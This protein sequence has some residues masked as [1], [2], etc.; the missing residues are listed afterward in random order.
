MNFYSSTEYLDAVSDVYFPARRT[1]VQDVSIGN[2]ALRLLVVDERQVITDS[3]FLDYHQPLQDLDIRIPTRPHVYAE[4]VVKNVINSTE[5]DAEALNRYLPAPFIKWSN[6]SNYDDYLRYVKSRS[7]GALREENRLKRRLSENVGKLEFSFDDTREDVLETAL[8]WKSAQFV[9]TG[10]KDIFKEQQN[11]KFLKTLRNRRLLKS[12][13]LRASDRLLSVMLGFEHEGTCSGW[14][15][16]YNPD[17][18]LRRYSI[19]RQM[20]HHMLTESFHR[21]HNE[22]DFSIGAQDYK[23]LYSTHIRLLSGVG[24]VPLRKR[25]GKSLRNAGAIWQDILHP[26]PKDSRT[27]K[28][29]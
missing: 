25:I 8:R 27:Q 12:S 17:P 3:P 24:R 16:T 21:G 4:R 19:G 23:F 6:F 15:F 18:S 2:T 7:K 20:L 5:W 13:T 28:W 11:V 29:D 14:I 26:S 1:S 22:F 10:L 9:R